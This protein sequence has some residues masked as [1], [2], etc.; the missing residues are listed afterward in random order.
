[1]SAIDPFRTLARRVRG[2]LA[3]LLPHCNLDKSAGGATGARLLL[4]LGKTGAGEG[5]RTLDPNFGKVQ[6]A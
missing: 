6:A 5:I 1:M 4:L 3:A 2:E